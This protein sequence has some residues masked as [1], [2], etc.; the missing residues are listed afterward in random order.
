MVSQAGGEG[1][2]RVSIVVVNY[3]GQHHLQPCFESLFELRYP[4][5]RLEVILVDNHSTDG[6]IELVRDRF[7]T[8]KV[9][10]NQANLG[11]ARANNIGARQAEGEYVAF[12][13]NDMRVDPD[14]VGALL[15]VLRPPQGAICAA[16]TILSWDGRRIDFVGGRMNF[17]GHGFQ[18]SF[19][20]P[21]QA[22]QLASEPRGLPFPC[23]GAM[24]IDRRVFLGVG[25][26]DE[27]YFAF[28]EDVDL[29]WRL[30]VL[31]YQV[32]YAPQAIVYH[33]HHGTA[34][35]IPP[36]Q[37]HVLYERNALYSVI[38]NYEQQNLDRVL[39][40]A[41]LLLAKR[42]VL[43]SGLDRE[44]YRLGS[45]ERRRQEA[46]SRIGLA[47]LLAAE[48]L[49]ERLPEVMRK[50]EVI[51]TA[52]RRTDREVFE[53]WNTSLADPT[54]PGREY[55]SAQRSLMSVMGLDG[56]FTSFHRSRVLLLCH[57]A[58]GKNMA[59]PAMRYWELA[60]VLGRQFEVTLAHAGDL[61]GEGPGFLIAAYQR[62]DPQSLAALVEQ[63]D[64]IV[65]YGYLLQTFP[66]LRD[67]GKPL[68][69]DIYDVFVLENLEHRAQLP[70][71]EQAQAADLDLGVLNAVL[72]AG[73]FYLCAS[74]RQRDFWLGMLAANGRLN[75]HNYGEDPTLRALIGVVPFG[76]RSDPPQRT[77][78][79]LKGVHP[80]IAVADRLLLWGGGLW[81]W[82]DPETLVKALAK[83]LEHRQDVKLFFM[84]KQ[85]FDRA[86][87]PEMHAAGRALQLSRELGLLDRHV[88]FG[89][90]VPYEERVN[91]LLE[92]DL[93]VSLHNE[94]VEAHFAFRT[95][96][97]DYIWAGLPILATSGDELADL[98]SAEGLGRVVAARDVEGTAAAIL[99]LLAEENLRERLAGRFAQVA[100]RFTWERCAEPLARFLASPRLAADRCC[101]VAVPDSCE[102]KTLAEPLAATVKPTPY[103]RLP[104]KAWHCLRNGG[105]RALAWE[106][107][108]YWHWWR[109]YRRR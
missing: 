84:A 108:Q 13:N 87:V 8:V 61:T 81:D 80:K 21:F 60:R 38:K 4:R 40:A 66:E 46:V 55:A 78:P 48:E 88:F 98:V 29:G 67:C 11:F 94:G 35:R 7:P 93:G 25:G 64:V 12:L 18:P 1:D 86:V 10:Q 73:D 33:R 31:G 62:S 71:A 59:G 90:W 101:G 74:E 52:R 103:W 5:E 79:A 28:F 106:L 70:L 97:L 69:L 34:G 100:A 6:S 16:S 49:L 83:V 77:G 96:L 39:P 68:V 92:A 37:L 2:P 95:R 99:E 44:A 75:P 23:G 53:L 85:H 3:N 26:F 22:G 36:H 91:Y 102:A 56:Y 17:Y 63:A 43:Q 9:I 30:W 47:G 109:N 57:E 14:W 89:D 45:G 54:F 42:A 32:L 105:P 51:Q 76:L 82:F 27:A 19:G 65:A 50:R 15:G 58:V 24:L 20:A 41:L 107:R 104:G 72:R